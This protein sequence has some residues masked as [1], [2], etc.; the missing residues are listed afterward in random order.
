MVETPF[1]AAALV[2]A[3]RSLGIG[4]HAVIDPAADRAE[5]ERALRRQLDRFRALRG[6]EPTHLD[7]H[8]HAHAIP[9]VLE[10]FAA[11]AAAARLPVRAIDEAMRRALRAKGIATADRFLGDADRRPAWT[12][13]ALRAALASLSDGVTEL[14][15]HPG[16]APSHARTSFGVEREIE[17]DAL[18]D[19]E[20]RRLV[21]A[22]GAR[23]GD[24]SDVRAAIAEPR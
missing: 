4:L 15:A 1:S 12:R 13:S 17:L 3:P 7:G 5:A 19:P 16:H 14:M 11:V 18:C 23:L 24:Y 21:A 10:A 22:A 8:K 9:Q 2:A 20:A 6:A